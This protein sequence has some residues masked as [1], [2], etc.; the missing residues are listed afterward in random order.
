MIIV[1]SGNLEELR[2][3][4]RGAITKHVA[5]HYR[6]FLRNQMKLAARET[7][8]QV[9]TILYLFRVAM[10]G[11]HLLRT[12]EVEAN[13]RI[14]NDDVFH[15]SDIPELIERKMASGEHGVLSSDE[16]HRLLGEAERLEGTLEAAAE[17]SMLPDEVGN[18]DA[19]HDFLV[20]SRL[21]V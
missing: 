3:L 13:V 11:I 4:A 7:V 17:G 5:H 15:R 18:L 2:H 1:D 16:R 14:L 8:P 12:G 19:I 20:R 6:G 21:S 9:K 10:T